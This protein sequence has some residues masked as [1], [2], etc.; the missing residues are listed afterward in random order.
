[1]API[2]FSTPRIP[3]N[4]E[5][6]SYQNKSGE[7]KDPLITRLC[8]PFAMVVVLTFVWF[9]VRWIARYVLCSIVY[10]GVDT[11]LTNYTAVKTRSTSLRR[12]TSVV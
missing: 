12:I 11:I 1:M 3:S 4:S 9:L 2:P 7:W 10:C 6:T 8:W 5:R